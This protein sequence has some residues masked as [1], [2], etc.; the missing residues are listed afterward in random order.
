M[1]ELPLPPPETA[2]SEEGVGPLEQAVYR[3]G[4]ITPRRVVTLAVVGQGQR[5]DIK[6][7]GKL[8]VLHLVGERRRAGVGIRRFR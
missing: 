2:Y 1:H 7:R 3:S 4:V 5:D 8:E 6:Q